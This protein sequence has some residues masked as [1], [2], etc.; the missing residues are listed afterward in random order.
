[1]ACKLSL[2]MYFFSVWK[3]ILGLPELGSDILVLIVMSVAESEIQQY[4]V[5]AEG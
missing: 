3:N 2:T 1:M 4:V 5:Y